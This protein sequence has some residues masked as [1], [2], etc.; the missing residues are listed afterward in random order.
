LLLESLPSE[1]QDPEI[2]PVIEE[3]IQKLNRIELTAQQS[4]DT[5]ILARFRAIEAEQ[6]KELDARASVWLE[7]AIGRWP[8]LRDRIR[9]HPADKSTKLA[10]ALADEIDSVLPAIRL[11]VD[12]DQLLVQ[13][14]KE[15]DVDL[16][17]LLVLFLLID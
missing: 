7:A 17:A 1:A 8:K 14:E 3:T 10:N 5:P 6:A 9:E 12:E 16:A 13:R 4:S 15:D 11:T 2:S